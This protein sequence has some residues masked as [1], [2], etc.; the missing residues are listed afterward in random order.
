MVQAPLILGEDG[1]PASAR[2]FAGAG[3]LDLA[4]AAEARVLGTFLAEAR[5]FWQKLAEAPGKAPPLPRH[6]LAITHTSLGGP[7]GLIW[8]AV[9]D[10]ARTSPR[11]TKMDQ[12]TKSFS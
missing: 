10:R 7:L 12:R 1:V 11:N 5:V 2:F 6:Y 4:E 8:W 9:K 3:R